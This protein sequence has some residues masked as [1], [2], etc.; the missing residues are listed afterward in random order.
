M[1][2]DVRSTTAP[3]TLGSG[4]GGRAASTGRLIAGCAMQGAGSGGM[5]MMLDL[6]VSDLVPLKKRESFMGIIF[7]AV[8]IGTA[9]G[10]LIGGIIVQAMAYFCNVRL[11]RF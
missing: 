9:F 10:P 1:Q 11:N 2:A 6:V 4:V 8:N 3:F 5:V 7:A